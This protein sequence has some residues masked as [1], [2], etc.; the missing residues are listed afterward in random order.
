MGV[1]AKKPFMEL[2]VISGK[3][4]YFRTNFAL[5]CN[6]VILFLMHQLPIFS[7]DGKRMVHKVDIK[8]ERCTLCHDIGVTER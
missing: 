1:D 3:N 8:L 6:C 4:C 5:P 7:A 2:G